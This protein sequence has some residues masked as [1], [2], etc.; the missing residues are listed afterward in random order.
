MNHLKL[1]F[2]D[3]SDRYVKQLT[4]SIKIFARQCALDAHALYFVPQL[5]K[6]LQRKTSG[7]HF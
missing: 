5:K 1:I 6:S 3:D 7:T 4:D 2:K